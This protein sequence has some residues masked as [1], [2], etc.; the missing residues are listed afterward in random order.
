MKL[1]FEWNGAK[2]KANFRRHGV[3]FDLAKA[4]FSDPFAVERLDE[5]EEHGE[6]RF[7]IIGAAEGEALLFVAYTER[8]ERIRIISARRATQ[9]EQDDYFRQ[10]A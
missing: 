10:N 5:R 1:E 9:N 8:E 3:S 6:E 7:V 2:A 4:V